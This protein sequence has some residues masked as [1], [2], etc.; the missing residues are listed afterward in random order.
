MLVTNRGKQRFLEWALRAE[1]EPTNLYV[2]LATSA[3]EPTSDMKTVSEITEVTAGNGY[4]TG[5][6]Q[7][8]RNSTDFDSL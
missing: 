3:I 7:I 4:A 8:S 2:L 6:F 1:N 5:G